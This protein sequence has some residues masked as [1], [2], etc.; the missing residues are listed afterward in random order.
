MGSRQMDGSI[1]YAFGR[2]KEG[3]KEE[4]LDIT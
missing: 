1:L 4:A 3:R 2:R